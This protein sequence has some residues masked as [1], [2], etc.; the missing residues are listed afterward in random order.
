MKKYAV[1]IFAAALLAGCAIGPPEGVFQVKPEQLTRRQTETRMY[2]GISG[3]GVFIASANVLQDLG[4]TIDKSESDLHIL[5]A[6]KTRNATDGGDVAM[7]V[8]SVLAGK[9]APIKRDQIIRVTLVERPVLDSDRK[10][11]PDKRYVRVSFMRII[12]FSDGNSSFQAITDPEIYTGFHERL[13]KSVFI[14][15]Q[16]I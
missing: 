5:T 15:A 14:E 1:P 13:S 2:S 10:E 9:P 11:I 8:L 6:S 4:Y 16:K 12:R 7:L 3:E